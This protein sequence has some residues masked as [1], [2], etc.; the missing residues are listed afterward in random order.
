[1]AALPGAST[2]RAPLVDAR[3]SL[4]SP[5]PDAESADETADESALR[6]CLLSLMP[7]D[8]STLTTCLLFLPRLLLRIL[9]LVPICGGWCNSTTSPETTCLR[10]FSNENTVPRPCLWSAQ[11]RLF[12]EHSRCSR[13]SG[14]IGCSWAERHR[15]PIMF[16]AFSVSFAA[17]IMILLA[18][19]ALASNTTLVENF[20]WA[21]GSIHSHGYFS[22]EVYLG[23][24]R[25]VIDV[26]EYS[27]ATNTT[28]SVIVTDWSNQNACNG[29]ISGTSLNSTCQQCVDSLDSVSTLAITSVITQTIQL[30]T[31]LQRTTPYGDMNCQKIMGVLTGVYGLISGLL[32]LQDFAD[33]C[34]RAQPDSFTIAGYPEL[35]E[36]HAHF[37]YGFGAVLIFWA[38]ALKAVDILCH[39]IV[40]T[41]RQKRLKPPWDP[42]RILPDYLSIGDPGKPTRGGYPIKLANESA[43]VS[44]VL[45]PL[46]TSSDVTYPA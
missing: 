45:P 21:S 33:S 16:F 32:S 23:M 24:R 20:A 34:W 35:G 44:D 2:I 7:A 15:S 3:D 11:C 19:L 46:A 30:A 9:V 6:T 5:V 1:M 39:A 18:S 31:D 38:T 36:V 8:E 37:S 40:P 41:P 29:F 42:K 25:R 43:A 27:N 28:H 12:F 14:S 17:W 22:A 10:Q 4:A 13:T 26:E